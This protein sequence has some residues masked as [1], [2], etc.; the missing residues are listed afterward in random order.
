M[1]Q[2]GLGGGQATGVID[3][4][5]LHFG[6]HPVGN[7]V[8][9]IRQGARQENRKQQPA[10][11]QPGPSVQPGHGLAEALFHVRAIQYANP[12]NVAIIALGSNTP[13]QARQAV[14]QAKHQMT[15]NR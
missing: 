9:E 15:A 1:L 6:L 8:L 7:F 13:N 2:I 3:G 5:R 14:R 11:D 12:A 4:M 10:K